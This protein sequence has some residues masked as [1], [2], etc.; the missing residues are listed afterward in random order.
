MRNNNFDILC[1]TMKS[2]AQDQLPDDNLHEYLCIFLAYCF[3]Y[4]AYFV[5]I[6]HSFR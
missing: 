4:L 6:L 5:H 3:T 1:I 2:L